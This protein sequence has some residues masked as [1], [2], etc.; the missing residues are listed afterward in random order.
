MFGKLK[1]FH[2]KTMDRY[3]KSLE[4]EMEPWKKRVLMIHE[5]VEFLFYPDEIDFNGERGRCLIR[6][7]LVR[8]QAKQGDILVLLD[9]QGNELARGE[10]LSDPGEK[11][12]GRRG[13][14]D[15]KRNEME[16]NLYSIRE[17]NIEEFDQ[18]AYQYQLKNL[19]RTLSMVVNP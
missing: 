12:I 10:L 16:M 4:E 5:L 1:D 15:K 11:E 18:R 13:V 19:I 8:G 9:G 17:K 3:Q 2:K 14:F 7:E 6:G